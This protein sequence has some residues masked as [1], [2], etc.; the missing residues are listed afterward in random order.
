MQ[1]QTQRTQ[2]L[3]NDLE[4][5]YMRHKEELLF[6]G[7]HH[8]S[9]VARKSV[10]F[11]EE[12]HV[13]KEL[14]EAAALTHD[15]NYIVDTHS[16]GPEKGTELQT[17]Y[18]SQAGFSEDEIAKIHA[19]VLE[20]HIGTRN[21]SISDEAKALAD[22]D[23]L[24]KVMPLTPVLFSSKFIT[25]TKVDIRYWAERIIREQKPLLEQGIYF[26]TESAKKKYLAWAKTDLQ[27][28]EQVLEALD[29]PAVQEMLDI[30]YK[31]KVI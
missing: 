9:F 7:W 19:V 3:R 1:S 14:V 17:K 15:L 13:D 12:L 10:E 8:I 24:F 5:L 30:A 6:H 16:E 28:V 4:K 2:Q 20:E 27:L 11:A 22:A 31:L 26:Y 23:C 18:L 21:A 25:E 29:D